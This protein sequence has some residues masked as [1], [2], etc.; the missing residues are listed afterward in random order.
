MFISGGENVYPAEVENVL[1]ACPGVVDAAV[2]PRPDPKWGEVGRA[3]VQLSPD[4]RPD[5]AELTAFCRSRLA[6]YKVPASFEVV[7]ISR[8]PRRGRSRSICWPERRETV[9]QDGLVDRRFGRGERIRTSG[10]CLPKTVLYQAE[11]LPDRYARPHRGRRGRASIGAASGQGKRGDGGAAPALLLRLLFH[12]FGLAFVLLEAGIVRR[13]RRLFAALLARLGLRRI[14]IGN[15]D[16]AGRRS[17]CSTG[18]TP[19]AGGPVRLSLPVGAALALDL[20]DARG[21]EDQP[22][23]ATIRPI[24]AKTAPL[25]TPALQRPAPRAEPAGQAAPYRRSAFRHAGDRDNC[26]RRR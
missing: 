10:P 20:A 3:F 23:H 26:R 13:D 14:D 22:S 25:D 5:E 15:D 2:L 4:R 9:R 16:V 7:A 18:W 11:L 8:A 19:L 6:A 12:H 1:A 24:T 21:A 17:R